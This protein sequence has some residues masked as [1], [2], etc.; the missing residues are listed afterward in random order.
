MDNT[1]L[2][3][4]YIVTDFIACII[5]GPAVATVTAIA[6]SGSLRGMA[7]AIAGINASNIIWCVMVGVGLVALVKSAPALFTLLGWA[8]ISYL[9]WMGIQTWR[10]NAHL[11]TKR[12]GPAISAWRGFAGAVAV[13]LSN[14][15]ALVFYTVF[16][17]PFVNVHKPVAPQLVLL[18]AIGIT[19]ETLVL[20]TYGFLAYRLGGLSFS[21]AAERRMAHVTGAVFILIALGMAVMRLSA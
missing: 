4:A 19:L 1:H 13:Q 9:L 11:E 6:L 20:A 3:L 14:P 8:G 12:S 17:P 5:P 15:K 2:L 16:L 10:S 18:A 7:G 21:A